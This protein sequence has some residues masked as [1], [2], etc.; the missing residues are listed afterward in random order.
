MVKDVWNSFKDNI[1][2]R[3]T[4]PFLGTFVIVWIAHNWEVVYSFFYFDKDWKLETKIKYFKDYWTDKSFFWNLVFV[5]LITIGI[6]IITYLFLALSRYL[7][8]LFEN[9]IIPNIQKISKGK[10]VTAEI[11]QIALDKISSLETKVEVE[12][13]AKNDALAER[14]EFERK[15]N[16]SQ[17]PESKIEEDNELKNGIVISSSLIESAKSKF[18]KEILER[19][20]LN[21][22]KGEYFTINNEIIDFLLK[23]G[24]VELSRRSSNYYFYKFTKTGDLFNKEY[25]QNF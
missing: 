8:N 1:K 18:D 16:E 23:N 17:N 9:V 4:N 10:I 2:D 7:A 13:K 14:D 6:L 22:S 19:T 12:R 24:L 20:L 25:F 11:H 21:I 5:A 15:L 3:V